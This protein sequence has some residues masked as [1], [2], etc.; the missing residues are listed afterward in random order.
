MSL[1]IKEA[2]ALVKRS[3]ATIY[4][5]KADGCDI[6]DAN[7]LRQFSD[8][9]DMR[10]RGR[11]AN[12]ALDR[13]LGNTSKRGLMALDYMVAELD[14]WVTDFKHRLAGTVD[15]EERADLTEEI[16]YLTEARRLVEMVAGG[17]R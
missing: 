8:L 15:A 6:T 3:R 17:Y 16:G 7:S 13:D 14:R 11:S 12:L 10:A 9:A 1:S 5:F 4:R 2:M